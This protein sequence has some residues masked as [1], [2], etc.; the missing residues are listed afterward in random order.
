MDIWNEG[1]SS[2]DRQKSTPPTEK[3]AK[4]FLPDNTTGSR[5]VGVHN[6]LPVFP[7]VFFSWQGWGVAAFTTIYCVSAAVY[8]R[9]KG[10]ALKGEGVF[11]LSPPGLPA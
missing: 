1:I 6:R 10:F 2:D 9:N 8:T 11:C 3:K 4:A 5:A 7:L